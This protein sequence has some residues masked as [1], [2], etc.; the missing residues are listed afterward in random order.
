MNSPINYQSD[1][2]QSDTNQSDYDTSH[3]DTDDNQTLQEEDSNPTYYS[4]T[5]TSFPTTSEENQSI[6]LLSGTISSDVTC[7]NGI[8]SDSILCDTGASH[9][10]I[11]IAMSKKLELSGSTITKVPTQKISIAKKGLQL[12]S[13][14]LEI[15]VYL[16]FNLC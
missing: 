6:A 7:E 12:Q 15:K 2:S 11:S 13:E 14:G 4:I 10:Y 9:C 1:V 5:Q 8:K 3:Y 16:K